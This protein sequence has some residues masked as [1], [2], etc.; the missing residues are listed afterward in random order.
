MEL[1][2]DGQQDFPSARSPD[3]PYVRTD[4][5]KKVDEPALDFEDDFP[6][7]READQ[8]LHRQDFPSAKEMDMGSSAQDIPS[9][10]DPNQESIL[11]TPS[12]H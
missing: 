12:A 8:Q 4:M 6:S 7:S 1:G 2:P 3:Q 10:Y 9:A 11:L 5:T